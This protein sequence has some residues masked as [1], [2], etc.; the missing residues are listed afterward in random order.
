MSVCRRNSGTTATPATVAP[1]C[2]TT[3]RRE[4][5]LSSKLIAVSLLLK[6]FV[7]QQGDFTVPVCNYMERIS[8]QSVASLDQAPI[9][10]CT[11][12]P[13]SKGHYPKAQYTRGGITRG[14]SLSRRELAIQR[15]TGEMQPMP[16]GEF[17][18]S[19]LFQ[20]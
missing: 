1:R 18:D 14:K 8:Q 12:I 11:K 2:V 7:H 15:S 4:I 3:S 6:V 5:S 9:S 17:I 16:H 20:L 19:H 13:G 10:S